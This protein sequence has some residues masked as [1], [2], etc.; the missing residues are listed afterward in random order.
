MP[1]TPIHRVLFIAFAPKIDALDVGKHRR[2][3]PLLLISI[4]LLGLQFHF[5]DKSL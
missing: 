2:F 5:G 3:I 4:T 1:D